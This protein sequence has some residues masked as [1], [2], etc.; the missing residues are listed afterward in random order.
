VG[1]ASEDERSAV[2]STT[3]TTLRV[4]ADHCGA[5]WMQ[6]HNKDREALLGEASAFCAVARL[7]V[8]A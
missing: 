8:G 1:P 4:V 7:V 3:P 2:Q 6:L 5:G